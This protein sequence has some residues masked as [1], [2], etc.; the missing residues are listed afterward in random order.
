MAASECSDSPNARNER[1]PTKSRVPMRDAQPVPSRDGKRVIFAS[2]WT[3]HVVMQEPSARSKQTSWTPSLA[4][5]SHLDV[6]GVDGRVGL[7]GAF[8]NPSLGSMRVYFAIPTQGPGSITI[9]DIGGRVVARNDIA[10][11]RP[12]NH[13]WSVPSHLHLAPGVYYARL[14]HKGV[15]RT[16][17]IVLLR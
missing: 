1:D 12:G 15:V 5:P 2:N 16:S 3:S 10:N 14:S 9:V 13:V 11:L 6:P 7:R 4:I 8:P 17:S